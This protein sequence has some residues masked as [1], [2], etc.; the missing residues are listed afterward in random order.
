M[1]RAAENI[2]RRAVTT[3]PRFYTRPPQPLA[4]LSPSPWAYF[5]APVLPS[6]QSHVSASGCGP[7]VPSRAG[8]CSIR[9]PW[10]GSWLGLHERWR[11]VSGWTW[12]LCLRGAGAGR[13]AGEG[14]CF[15][16]AACP[17]SGAAAPSRTPRPCAPAHRPAGRHVLLPLGLWVCGWVSLWLLFAFSGLCFPTVGIPPSRRHIDSGF[18]QTVDCVV[19]VVTLLSLSVSGAEGAGAPTRGL[20]CLD[21]RWL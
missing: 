11:A 12:C 3:T 9:W 16:G 6:P 15:P 4:E 13:V 19:G 7:C 5:V 21:K 8:H 14:L 2:C 17:L 10:G 20:L 1:Y 18:W